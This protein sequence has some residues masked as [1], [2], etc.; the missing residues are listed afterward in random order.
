M[1]AGKKSMMWRLELNS[2]IDEARLLAAIGAK[3]LAVSQGILQDYFDQSKECKQSRSVVGYLT[4]MDSR[5]RRP[6]KER[7][8]QRISQWNNLAK[9]R[10]NRFRSTG[11]GMID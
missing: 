3:A 5:F 4:L 10:Q 2:G 7:A 9:N 8:M 6:T 1:R 11:R